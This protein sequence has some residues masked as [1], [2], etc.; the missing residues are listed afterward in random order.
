MRL[1][2][3]FFLLGNVK[4]LFANEQSIAK[5]S[6]SITRYTPEKNFRKT[7]HIDYQYLVRYIIYSTRP[8]TKDNI[9]FVFNEQALNLKQ[10]PDNHIFQKIDYY[11]YYFNFLLEAEDSIFAYRTKLCVNIAGINECSV[12]EKIENIS[13]KPQF[14]LIAFSSNYEETFNTAASDLKLAFESQ[15]DKKDIYRNVGLENSLAEQVNVNDAYQIM[16]E[17]LLNYKKGIAPR[18]DDVLIFYMSMRPYENYK[19]KN[20]T[21]WDR[22]MCNQ[23]KD[24]F[25]VN[26]LMQK[27]AQL[28]NKSILITDLP[29]KEL[30]NGL[31][32]QNKVTVISYTAPKDQR[33]DGTTDQAKSG[34]NYLISAIKNTL[35]TYADAN[36]DSQI[37]KNEM[38]DYLQNNLR[39]KK[40]RL[41]VINYTADYTLFGL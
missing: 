15:K 24:A 14:N 37:S 8:L 40:G 19:L 25:A 38:V 39:C 9:Q 4:F 5:D 10:Y 27:M 23:Y 34:E 20:M 7:N 3:L 33:N 18:A 31:N 36:K 2:L 12:N 30:K 13:S 17:L 11:R 22:L 32:Y 41:A 26:Q 6:L 21:I 29:R 1:L 28:P 16:N 35:T